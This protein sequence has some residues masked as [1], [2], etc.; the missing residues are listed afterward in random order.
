[1][2]TETPNMDH[3][4]ARQVELVHEPIAADQHLGDLQAATTGYADIGT[5]GGCSVGIWEMST[6]SM[7]DIEE[8]EYFVVLSGHGAVQILEANGFAEQTQQLDAG[9]LVR[10]HA[11]MQTV[12]HVSET[13]RK[14]YLTPTS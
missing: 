4:A 3:I 5:L 1:M 7:K 14:I 10:L 2:N 12:W 8:D 9:S 6:G 11:G 13:L